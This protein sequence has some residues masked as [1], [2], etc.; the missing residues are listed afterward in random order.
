MGGGAARIKIWVVD[1]SPL[2]AERA[3][4][5]LSSDYDVTTFTDPSVSLER[6]AAG[7]APDILVLDWMMPNLSGI[8]VC[9]FLRSAGGGHEKL[10]IL[11][12]TSAR[13]T[14]QIVAGLA[15]GADDYLPKP[16]SDAELC[17]RIGALARTHQLHLRSQRAEARIEGLLS[18]TPDAIVAVDEE[19]SIVFAN[20]QATAVFGA[21]LVGRSSKE[22][23]PNLARL[24]PITHV[25]GVA[26]TTNLPDITIEGRVYAP[27]L[28]VGDDAS[29]AHATVAFRDVTVT[30]GEETRRMDFYSMVAHDMRSPLSAML[31]RNTLIEMGR[32]GVVS[33]ALLGEVRKNEVTMKS[34]LKLINDF[35]DFARLEGAGLKLDRSLIEMNGLARRS[36]DELLPLADARKLQI[37]LT[38]GAR[39]AQ[40]MG[41]E[42]RLMQVFINLLS[43][44]I[45]F[46]PP[47]GS[48]EVM[49]LRRDHTLEINVKDTGPGIPA[50]AR[51]T[52]FDRFTRVET[53]GLVTAGTGLGL[54]IAKQIVEAHGGTIGLESEV[55]RGSRVWFALPLAPEPA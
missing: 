47:G 54:M 18:G 45:K 14:D 11:L 20:S 2:D 49:T 3:R 55:G 6:L 36:M 26:S 34:L 1:D 51:A 43:N 25:A 21:G 4:R 35:T 38:P 12:L 50:D 53:P 42:S 30:R 5:A 33:P 8:E 17:A 46:T 28:R 31:I 10:G 41:D 9:Q 24:E 19:G 40:V 52:I 16:Y 13:E 37:E 15:A 44:A 48:I 32:F 23:L 29:A 7:P 39:G 27:T 22:L